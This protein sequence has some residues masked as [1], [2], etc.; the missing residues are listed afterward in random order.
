VLGALLYTFA[1][2]VA[3]FSKKYYR[4]CFLLLDLGKEGYDEIEFFLSVKSKDGVC[5]S[6][7]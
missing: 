6:P 5:L 7:S 4:F 1:L 2:T 3:L